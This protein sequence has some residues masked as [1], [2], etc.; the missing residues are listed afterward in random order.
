MLDVVVVGAGPIGSRAAYRLALQGHSVTVLEKRSGPGL[1]T[2]CTGIISQECVSKFNIPPEVVYRQV[3]SASLFSPSGDSLRVVRPEIQAHVVDRSAFDRYLAGLASDQGIKYQYHT[4]VESV[5][6]QSDRVVLQVSTQGGSSVIEA[7]AV[8]LACGF[9]TPLVRKS[10]LGQ[11]RYFTTGVQAEVQAKGLEEIEIYF[12]HRIAPGFFAWLV[13]TQ[14]GRALAGLMSHKYAGLYLRNWLSD[15]AG[16]GK[17]EAGLNQIY[18]SGIPM[19]PLSHTF[20]DRLL[21]VGD[22]AGQVKPTT[23]GGLYFGL[24]C[25]DIAAET[26]HNALYSDNLSVA[27][28]SDY[29]RRWQKLIGN[30]LRSEYL[31]RRLYRYF[32]DARIDKLFA[33][34]KSQGWVDKVMAKNDV[35]FDWHGQALSGMI[36]QGLLAMI[37]GKM[38]R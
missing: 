31:A 13:P 25:A 10:G 5:D 21:V 22:A 26:L 8:V 6:I 29:Q 2:C 23:G 14:D 3:R 33:S 32:S 11:S 27:C 9:N 28:L 30:E 17:I 15:L 38:R 16:Q 20:R 35:G 4:A 19:Y 37:S 1:K 7:K 34:A 36:R 24:L 12:G 18:Y